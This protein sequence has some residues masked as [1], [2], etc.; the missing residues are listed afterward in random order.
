M[1]KV[2]GKKIKFSLKRRLQYWFDNR[3]EVEK[4]KITLEAVLND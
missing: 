4:W 3:K 1:K 2:R